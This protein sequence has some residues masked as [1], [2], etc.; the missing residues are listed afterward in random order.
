MVISSM[1]TDFGQLHRACKRFPCMD[2][3]FASMKHGMDDSNEM[4][5]VQEESEGSTNVC[6]ICLYI[7]TI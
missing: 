5:E 3:G 2:H 4:T 1:A 7:V 6:C